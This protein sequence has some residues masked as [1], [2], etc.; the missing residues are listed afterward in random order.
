MA[1]VW[2]PGLTVVHPLYQPRSWPILSLE[3]EGSQ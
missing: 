1:G 3:V 2:A